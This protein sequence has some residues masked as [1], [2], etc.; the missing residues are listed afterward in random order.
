MIVKMTDKHSTSVW[1]R[2]QRKEEKEL[3]KHEADCAPRPEKIILW[4]NGVH[5]KIYAS[6]TSPS[7][8]DGIHSNELTG[9]C[10]MMSTF[11]WWRIVYR[12]GQWSIIHEC[13]LAYSGCINQFPIDK[14]YLLILC[15]SFQPCVVLGTNWQI[16]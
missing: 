12:N 9:H 1:E 11:P 14:L 4:S 10:Q 7:I 5:C 3:L 16:C 6:Q 13:K 15:V 2:T 8:S